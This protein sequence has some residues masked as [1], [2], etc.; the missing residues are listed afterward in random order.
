M[1]AEPSGVIVTNFDILHENEFSDIGGKSANLN[2]SMGNLV[3]QPTNIIPMQKALSTDGGVG[4]SE[5]LNGVFS[6]SI[7]QS[8]LADITNRATT[9]PLKSSK[10]KWSRLL[11]EVGESDSSS[12]MEILESRRPEL[13]TLDLTIRKKKRVSPTSKGGKEN[14]Q[15]VA[16]S[17]HHQLQ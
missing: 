4:L 6:F 11:C 5:G 10:L 1:E 3:G 7:K 2:N 15:V 9:E 17:Q 13:E 16:G 12:D 8:P 14:D